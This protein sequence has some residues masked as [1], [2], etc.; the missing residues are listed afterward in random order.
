M[1]TNTNMPTPTCENCGRNKTATYI[2]DG[3]I[4]KLNAASRALRADRDRLAAENAELRKRIAEIATEMVADHYANATLDKLREVV[5]FDINKRGYSTHDVL[6]IWHIL[7]PQ[8]E[9]D[10]GN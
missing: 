9:N 2:C 8:P 1:S 3:C 10:N 4:N 7:Y 5:P 6:R